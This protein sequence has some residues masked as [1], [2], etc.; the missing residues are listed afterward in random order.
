MD[1]FK[2]P[3]AFSWNELITTDPAAAHKAATGSGGGGGAA[4]TNAMGR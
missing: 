1:V 2:T 4:L 3:G